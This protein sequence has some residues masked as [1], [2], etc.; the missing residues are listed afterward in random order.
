MCSPRPRHEILETPDDAYPAPVGEGHIELAGGQAA[1]SA[2]A[3]GYLELSGGRAGTGVAATGHL[4]LSGGSAQGRV[5]SALSTAALAAAGV[6]IVQ[7]TALD[8]AAIS[9]SESVAV[10]TPS[11]ADL[12]LHLDRLLTMPNADLANL[13]YGVWQFLV[14]VLTA[15]QGELL[16]AGVLLLPLLLILVARRMRP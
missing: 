14:A 5:M 12:L 2:A 3:T 16:I 4:E 9:V 10:A 7:V 6:E 1:A 15:W 11:E 8:G 13:A